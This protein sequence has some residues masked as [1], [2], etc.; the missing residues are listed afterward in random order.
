VTAK[1]PPELDSL[2]NG[3]RARSPAIFLIHGGDGITP[4]S[5]QRQVADA[6]A[7]PK[8]VIE[9]P[10][11]AHDAPL[12]KEAAGQ[13]RDAIDWLWKTADPQPSSGPPTNR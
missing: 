10:D 2:E 13:M 3:A 12:T 5:Y 4:A 7:G 1:L 11:A 6:Y 9:M 8:R